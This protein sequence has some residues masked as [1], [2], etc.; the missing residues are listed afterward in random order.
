LK[1]KPNSEADWSHIT[2]VIRGSQFFFS[3]ITACTKSAGMPRGDLLQVV[4]PFD[5]ATSLADQAATAHAAP[6]PDIPGVARDT[7]IGLRDQAVAIRRLIRVKMADEADLQEAM[8]S[9]SLINQLSLSIQKMTSPPINMELKD[10]LTV[11][12]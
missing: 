9:M 11:L 12:N 2:S 1:Q 10:L 6:L 7:L 8:A 5:N 4:L 3:Q